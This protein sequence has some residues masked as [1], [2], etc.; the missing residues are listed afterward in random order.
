VI[1]ALGWYHAR[2]GGES[3]ATPSAL[4]LFPVFV[5]GFLAAAIL[6]SIGEATLASRGLAY[7]VWDAGAWKA[8]IALIGERGSYWALGTAMAAVGLTTDLAVFKRL[9]LRPVYLGAMVTV[10]VAA[11]SLALAAAIGPLM[12]VE[13]LK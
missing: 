7:G 9:G 6:R 2:R 11:L 12:S 13:A 8:L 1:P 5:L 4:R 3:G 10:L